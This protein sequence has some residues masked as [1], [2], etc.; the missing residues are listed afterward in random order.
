VDYEITAIDDVFWLEGGE[1]LVDGA[2]DGMTDA[3]IIADFMATTNSYIDATTNVVVVATISHIEFDN[4]TPRQAL[5]RIAEIA[6]ARWFMDDNSK[7]HYFA[8]DWQMPIVLTDDSSVVDEDTALFGTFRFSEMRYGQGSQQTYIFYS[9]FKRIEEMPAATKVIVYGASAAALA[10]VTG[11]AIGGRHRATKL[12]NRDIQDASQATTHGQ[13]LL[14]RLTAPTIELSI[15]EPWLRAGWSVRVVNSLTNTDDWFII[16]SITHRFLGGGYMR[17][18]LQL[19]R[20]L[21]PLPKVL[22]NVQRAV[23]GG[24]KAGARGGGGWRGRGA[25]TGAWPY[26]RGGWTADRQ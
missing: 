2:Y 4:E 18:D 9:N 6:G 12:V 26:R 8:G 1:A 21:A 3:A 24:S 10:T 13:A 17:S 23:S 14:D 15:H 11:T 25:G 20:Y 19:G 22:A 16:N 7:L 5:E